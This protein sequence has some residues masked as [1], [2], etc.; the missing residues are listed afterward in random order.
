MS[1]PESDPREQK[2]VPAAAPAPVEEQEFDLL[3]FWIQYRKLIVRSLTLI[4]VGVAIYFGY[5]FTKQRKLAESA[6]ALASAKSADDLR[7]VTAEW[8]GTPAAGSA[9]LRLG[10]ELRRAGKYDEATKAIQEFAEKYPLHALQDR[11]L[12]S[13]GITQEL[14]GKTDEA[15]ATYQR[16][17]STFATSSAAADA[18]IRQ[19][20]IQ[21]AKGK[22]EDAQRILT[23]LEQQ[24][25]NSLYLSEA[26]ALSEEMK[27]PSGRILGGNPRPV[28][29]EPA[30]A[31]KK[32]EPAK[33][34]APAV[35][36][37]P[38]QTPAP[39]PATPP[40][41]DQQ[42]KQEPANTPAVPPASAPAPAETPEPPVPAK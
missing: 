5:E 16:V 28:Q 8:A 18:Q 42:N 13:F 39:A 20:R 41:A 36:S 22:M 37:A 14:A 25:K 24:H 1:E 7:K 27:N 23:A 31:E 29:P 35:I 33:N 2:P 11:A 26:K 32:P 9:L 34:K 15:F 10:D 3:A 38:V 17:V 12:I 30:E 6:Q 40:P 4:L 21:K 19:A